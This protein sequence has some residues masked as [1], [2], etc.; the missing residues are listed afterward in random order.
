MY[1]TLADTFEAAAQGTEVRAMVPQG[2]A[3]AF[4]AAMTLA[5]FLQ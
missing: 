3:A 2:D 5:D 4:S 1:S